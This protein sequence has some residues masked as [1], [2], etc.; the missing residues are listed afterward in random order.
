MDFIP[1]QAP[2]LLNGKPVIVNLNGQRI[3]GKISGIASTDRTICP[4]YII[5]CNDGTFPNE[6][7]PYS[8]FIA[9][10]SLISIAFF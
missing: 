7:Y 1:G 9:P 2:E 4:F 10:L 3:S 6:E 5:E 8:C